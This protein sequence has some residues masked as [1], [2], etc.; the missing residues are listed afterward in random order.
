MVSHVSHRFHRN[1]TFCINNFRCF[2]FGYFIICAGEGLSGVP[3]F[4]IVAV[5]VVVVVGLIILGLSWKR[6]NLTLSK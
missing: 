4:L 3:I 5:A 6:D 2:H 1:V